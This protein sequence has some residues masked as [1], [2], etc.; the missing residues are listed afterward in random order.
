MG[1]NSE[2]ELGNYAWYNV[3]SP[4]PVGQKRPNGLGLYDMCG[5]VR[6]WVQDWYGYY[7]SDSVKDPRG[8]RSGSCRVVRGGS[9]LNGSRGCRSANRYSSTPDR[10]FN[11]LGFRLARTQ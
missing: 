1:T 9:G 7:R 6:Q 2:S 10:R 8:P 5:N 3:S 11:D 4:H